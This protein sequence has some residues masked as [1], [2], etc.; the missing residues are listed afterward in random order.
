MKF[1]PMNMRGAIFKLALDQGKEADR[2]RPEISVEAVE[3]SDVKALINSG[4]YIWCGG[5][6]TWEPPYG[7][8]RVGV[9]SVRFVSEAS[10]RGRRLVVSEG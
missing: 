4:H 8:Y 3:M 7:R 10:G 1:K 6:S 9:D 5:G 2:Y